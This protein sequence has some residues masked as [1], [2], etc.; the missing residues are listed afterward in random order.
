[1]S[2]HR[3]PK[4]LLACALVLAAPLRAQDTA[5]RQS[6]E[7]E[8]RR[9][10]AASNAAIAR[11]DTAGIAAILAPHVVVVTS[12][13]ARDIGRD[14]HARQLAEH[15]RRRPDV[16]YERVP[17]EVMVFVPWRMASEQG[18][19]TGSWSDSDGKLSIGGL[20]FAKWRQVEG[21]WLVES[22]TY[23]P[24]RCTGGSYCATVP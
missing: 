11:H 6:A 3:R 10:R 15:F 2:P 22:E 19:W 17:A 7:Q 1:M 13:S 9:L 8:I 18:R 21:R 16:T 23:V 5:A 4:W 24:D 12:T 14:V 20:Y